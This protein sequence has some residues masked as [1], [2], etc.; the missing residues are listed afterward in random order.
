MGRRASTAQR[1]YDAAWQRVRLQVLRE[2]PW[3]KCGQKAK[4]VDHL[5]PIATHP[6][7]R[8]VR[9][10]LIAR[11]HACHSRRTR[12]EHSPSLGKVRRGLVAY[13]LDGYPIEEGDG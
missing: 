9:S 8:L 3:C 7:L 4:D 6:H 5:K 11:C 2:Q 13:D 12:I 10:N 1:G